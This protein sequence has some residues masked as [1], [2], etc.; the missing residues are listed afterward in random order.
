VNSGQLSPGDGSTSPGVLNISGNYIQTATGILTINV[1]G[2]TAGTGYGQLNISGSATLNGTLNATLFNGFAPAVEEQFSVIQSASEAGDFSTFNSSQIN[3]SPA[4]AENADATGAEI[5][6]VSN[7]PDLA[8]EA[9]T[10][11]PAQA[12]LGQNVTVNY[13]VDNLGTVATTAGSWTDSVYLSAGLALDANSI[14]L[15]HLTHIGDLAGLGS[16]NGSLTAALPGTLLGSYYVLVETD[17]RLAV[18]DTDRSNNTGVAPSK[19]SIDA[20]ALA[21]GTPVSGTIASGQDIYYRINASSGAAI[22]IAAT[23]QAAG[24]ANI[25][26][27]YD[28]IPSDS[29]FDES[30]TDPTVTNPQIQIAQPQGGDYYILI[31][32]QTDAG[33]GSTFT[34][35]ASVPG[36]GLNSVAPAVGSNAGQVT[37]TLT[38]S[39]FTPNS[40]ARLT[41][42]GG[43]VT[44]S[45]VVYDNA[46][47]IYATFDLTGLT[48]G[49]YDA[50]VTDHSQTVS[51]AGS[52]TVVTGNPGLLQTSLSTAQFVRLGASQTTV[53]ISYANTGDTDIPAPLLTVDATNAVLG[54]SDQS[55]FDGN[56][57]EVL[58]INQNG[59][60]GILPPGYHGTITLNY[61]PTTTAGSTSFNF[62]LTQLGD[63]STPIDWASMEAS[64]RPSYIN[65]TAWDAIFNNFTAAAGSTA[66]SYQAYLDGLATYFGEIGEPTSDFDQLYNFAISTLADDALPVTAQITAEDASV[67]TPGLPLTF[68]RTFASDISGRYNEGSLGYG[69]TD[70]WQIA[71]TVDGQGDVTVDDNG[72]ELYFASQS[73]GT[74]LPPAGDYATLSLVSGAY[75]LEETNGTILAFNSDGSFSY[76]QDANGNRITAGYSNGQLSSLTDTNGAYLDF[77]YNGQGHIS[78]IT[79]STGNMTNYTYDSTGN[80]LSNVSSA[81]ES[82]QYS[83]VTGSNE[84]QQYALST[85]TNTDGTHVYLTYDAQGRLTNQ[86]G[87]LCASNPVT[88]IIY[89]YGVG[90]TFTATDNTGDVTTQMVNQFGEAAITTDPLAARGETP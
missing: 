24:I 87:C 75:Q 73:I 88:H 16:Y 13:T 37:L 8:V 38:G 54:Y 4:F 26:V 11:T 33:S 31:E 30:A 23:Y 66:G 74:Y 65:A 35:N 77:A 46:S 72:E 61:Q 56:T 71:A 34:L 81:Q 20:P 3:S 9:V 67:P 21:L 64:L 41:G 32:G 79:D 83:Y 22:S 68:D 90:G 59:P 62:T 44:A 82:E 42:S 69:W 55:T 43:S 27:R 86:Q 48:A 89:G 50:E 58:G 63:S 47:T 7:A 25:Y 15:G 52:F 1:G 5:V 2:A 70:N 60:A 45:S 19:M 14:L 51:D 78:G 40:T 76:E 36:F 28:D 85:I 18:S 80:L 39:D 10:F 12:D 57:I 49:T 53:T 29:T 17:S 6:G 84:A